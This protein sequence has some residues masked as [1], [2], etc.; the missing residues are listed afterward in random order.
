MAT[1]LSYYQSADFLLKYFS[2]TFGLITSV[3]ICALTLVE[4]LLHS[5][6]LQIITPPS[7]LLFLQDLIT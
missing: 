4:M 2:N 5:K 3:L 1:S 6:L 7:Y